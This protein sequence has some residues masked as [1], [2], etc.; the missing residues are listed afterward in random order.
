MS[1]PSFQDLFSQH[2]ACYAEAR[3]GYP[4]ELFSYL[5]GLV[6]RHELA[7]DVGTGNGQAALSL[8]KHFKKVIATD[9]SREQIDHATPHERVEYRVALAEAADLPPGGIDLITVAQAL[10]WF[11]HDEFYANVRRAAAPHAVIAAWCYTLPRVNEAVD[12]VCDWFYKDVTGPYWPGDRAWVDSK[13]RSITFPFAEI[14]DQSRDRKGVPRDAEAAS[15]VQDFECRADW[16]L[17][18]YAAYIESWSAVQRYRKANGRDPMPLFE[19]R[20]PDAWGDPNL[21]LAAKFPIHLRV[22]YVHQ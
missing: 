7:W 2:A 21:R 18:Q 22:G 5:A 11:R 9:G 14:G 3:P 1:A 13:Y 19:A 20:L 4:P 12:A 16:S 8:A 6:P 10:H 17:S 15:A